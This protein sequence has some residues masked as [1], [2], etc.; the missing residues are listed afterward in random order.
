MSFDTDQTVSATDLFE[1][2]LR[3]DVHIADLTVESFVLESGRR[4]RLHDQL[5]LDPRPREGLDGPVTAPRLQHR[6]V[7]SA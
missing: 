3:V 7:L 1:L 6:L 4:L 5:G 2:S